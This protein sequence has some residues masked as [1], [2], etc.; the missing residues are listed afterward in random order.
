MEVLRKRKLYPLSEID[1]IY[2]GGGTYYVLGTGTIALNR[3]VKNPC[4]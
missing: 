3:M 4:P 1:Y 2:M